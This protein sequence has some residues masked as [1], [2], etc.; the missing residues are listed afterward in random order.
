MILPETRCFGLK[1][2]LLRRCGAKI[3]QGVRICSSAAF[4]GN[5]ELRIGKDTWIGHGVLIS[6]SSSVTIGE[7]VDIAPQ[8]YIGTGTHEIDTKGNHV[9]GRGLNKD[10]SIGNGVWLCTNS[11]ILPGVSIGN[12]SIVAAGAVVN[13]S[14]GDNEVVAGIPAKCIKKI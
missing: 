2:F 3:E 8:V 1:R 10:I 13:Q 7:Y 11:I 12:K 5:G 9:A 4:I 14:C 6:S